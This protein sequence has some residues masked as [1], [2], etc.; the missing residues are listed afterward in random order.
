MLWVS[1]QCRDADGGDHRE[2]DGSALD[3]GELELDEALEFAA[4]VRLVSTAEVEK[5]K[6]ED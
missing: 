2:D 1:A 5:L 6:E 3:L 4:H